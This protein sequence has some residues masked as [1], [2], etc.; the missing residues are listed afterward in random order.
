MLVVEDDYLVASNVQASLRGAELEVAGIA[1]TAEEAIELAGSQHPIL[2]LVDIRIGGIHDGV[3]LALELFEQHGIRSIFAT[4][5]YDSD[6]R[7]RAAP[8]HPLGWMQKPYSMPS[9]I[10]RIR[11]ALQNLDK[12]Q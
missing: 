1:T 10:A 12:A 3:D 4:A 11:E 5:H 8:A 9:L 6:V 7:A 2:A